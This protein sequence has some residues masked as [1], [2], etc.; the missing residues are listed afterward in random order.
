MAQARGFDFDQD[1]TPLGAFQ[2]YVHH[3]KRLT[4]GNGDGG[5]CFHHKKR[6]FAVWD[7][8]EKTSRFVKVKRV[9][10]SGKVCRSGRCPRSRFAAP[11]PGFP[12]IWKHV[13]AFVRRVFFLFNRFC[14]K[15]DVP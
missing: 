11:P 4:C 9:W 1:F 10:L 13:Y 14:D 8:R 3:L 6:P 2:I 5:A 15:D 7:K 12:A